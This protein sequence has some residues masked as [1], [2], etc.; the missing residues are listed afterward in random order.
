MGPASDTYDT[1]K[2]LA[3]AGMDVMRMNF[4]HGS[5]DDHFSKMQIIKK[6]NFD[7]ESHVASLLDTKGPEIRTHLFKDGRAE[8]LEGATVTIHMS[9]IEG[10]EKEFSI[11]YSNLYLDMVP[12]ERIL[13]DDGYLSL[14]V[15]KI[16]HEKKTIIAIA[17]N[18][19]VLKNTKGINL[20]STKNII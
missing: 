9:E 17:E 1:M 19:H 18:D 6:V 15:K 4:S 13:V 12:G 3:V 14:M 2:A 11:S 20:N 5:H 8:V 7:L 16:D 10:N